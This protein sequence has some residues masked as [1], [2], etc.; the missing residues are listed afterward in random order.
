[1]D[2]YI[3]GILTNHAK[4]LLLMTSGDGFLTAINI[5]ARK[6]Y[7]QSEPYDEE[8]TCMGLFRNESKLVV[9]S[10]KGRFYTYNWDE[11]GLHSNMF[12]GPKS[13]LSLMVPVTDRIA[14]TGG[15][16]GIVRAMHM[17][18]GRNLGVVGQ[19]PLGVEAM[20]ISNNGE[21]IASSSHEND[22]KF[23]NIKYFEDFPDLKYNEKHNKRRE[24]RHNLPSSK[25]GNAGDFFADMA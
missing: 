17:L 13:P 10:S 18:P 12:P 24:E 4:K 9:G 8:L 21:L 5:G 3:T 20:D 16:E 25:L 2:D 15:E 14:V 19:H 23:W 22:I 1:M 6:L 11:F 7:V